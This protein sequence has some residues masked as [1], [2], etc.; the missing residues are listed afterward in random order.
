MTTKS[1]NADTGS[2]FDASN[3]SPPS[4][5]ATGDEVI[6]GSGQPTIDNGSAITGELIVLGGSQNATAATLTAINTTFGPTAAFD[7]TLTATGGNPSSDTLDSVL[8][9]EGDT[10]FSGRIQV[11]AVGGSLTINSQKQGT[12][13]ANLTL[14]NTSEIQV[15]RESKLNLTGERITNNAAIKVNGGAE[16]AADLVVTGSGSIDVENGGVLLVEGTIDSK[17][18]VYLRDG[19]GDLHISNS[20]K[21]L[22]SIGLEDPGARIDLADLQ[23]QSAAYDSTAQQ[24]TLYSG[25]N[26]TGQ[27]L[28]TFDIVGN[29]LSTNDFRLSSDGGGGTLV[30]YAPWV[31][32]Y[33]PMPVPVVAKA[34]TFVSLSD[35]MLQSFGTASPGFYGITLQ[36]ADPA[37]A[38]G[39]NVGYWVPGAGAVA[40]VWY[41]NGSPITTESYQVQAS[42][43]VELLVGNS[44]KPVTIQAQLT[45]GSA[46]GAQVFTTYD[47]FMTDPA[48]TAR[49]TGTPTAAEVVAS[50]QSNFANYPIVPN[51]N[52]CVIIA[53]NVPAAAGAPI[54][55]GWDSQPISDF[56][57]NSDGGFWR[58]VYNSTQLPAPPANWSTEVEPGDTVSVLWKNNGGGHVF[59][60]LKGVAGN[61]AKIKVYDNV[62]DPNAKDDE[63]EDGDL[64][65]PHI[66]ISD[67]SYWLNTEPDKVLI[68]RLDPK[69]QYLIRGSIESELIQGSVYNNLINPG[70]G[71][72][73]ITAGLGNN[74]IQDTAQSLNGIT[75]TDF[76]LGDLFNFTNLGLSGT[77][78]SYAAGKLH[79]FSSGSEVAAVTMS[80]PKPGE[81]VAIATDGGV[82]TLIGLSVAQSLS[83]TLFEASLVPNFDA[84][85]T[86][87]IMSYLENAGIYDSALATAAVQKSSAPS[88][89]PFADIAEFSGA[90]I[91]PITTATGLKAIIATALNSNVALTGSRDV[92]L[93]SGKGDDL[94]NLRDIGNDLIVAG[95]GNDTIVTGQGRDTV[96]AGDGN[97]VVWAGQ[98]GIE[99]STNVWGGAGDDIIGDISS[100]QTLYPEGSNRFDGGD[101]NDSLY[102][103][104]SGDD[105]LTG[106]TGNDTLTGA[107]SGTYD[108]D[109]GD[110]NDTLI[111][112]GSGT[113]NLDGGDGNDLIYAAGTGDETA[114]GG[115]GDDQIVATASANYVLEG[116]AGNDRLYATGNGDNSL[117]GG[118]GNDVLFAGGVGN[119]SLSGDDGNDT[120]TGAGNGAYILDG[121][122]GDDLLY[123]RGQEIGVHA[124]GI[125]FETVLGG[126]GNDIILGSGN[127]PYL[128]DGGA[129]GDSVY[130]TGNGNDI[131]Q[132][133]DDADF[134]YVSGAGADSLS[135]GAGDDTVI[136][137]GAGTYTL[138][139]GD[140]NDLIYA[141][142]P[143]AETVLG[144]A[145]NDI[146][147][148]QGNGDYQLD[149]G[150][151]SDSIYALGN[152]NDLLQGDDGN[153]FLYANGSGQDSLT[154]N[155]GDDT[156]V[157]AG[158]GT[159]DLGGGDGN[160]LIYAQGAAGETAFGGAGNDTLQGS[161]AGDDVLDGGAG[162]NRLYGLGTGNETL[163]GGVASGNDTLSVIG[164]GTFLVDA[165][166]ATGNNSIYDGGANN[167]TII[168]GA[169]NDTINAVGDGAY[170]ISGGDGNDLVYLQGSGADSLDAGDGNDIV[171]ASG[172]GHYL[173]NGGAGDDSIYAI[174]SGNDTIDGGDGNDYISTGTGTE[175]DHR[176]RRQR[177]DILQL[178]L[179]RP[180]HPRRWRGQR[181]DHVPGQAEE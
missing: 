69:Q 12:T 9:I 106:G 1:W 122:G 123:A 149:G 118:I 100:G 131:L 40:P 23:V 112:T 115:N 53:N 89:D 175:F 160:D 65:K 145:G 81:N 45:S 90:H 68:Y 96:Q 143:R 155:D 15:T 111:G 165:S 170:S 133:G 114:S 162:D 172:A 64:F 16:V 84:A 30:T 159:Y 29:N 55:M 178:N 150:T 83:R 158:G 116:G 180:R 95:G 104:G 130:V 108:L 107:G 74:E 144:G 135:G 91:A 21:F 17:Q 139:G 176:R 3:W 70:G 66:G 42:D 88:V 105:S 101:G 41:V 148:G 78:A 39:D 51:R 142:G 125:G 156:V 157:G 18:I 26:H 140:G 11:E 132:G 31:Q 32:L 10:V 98:N 82:G 33:Q 94:L 173:I 167:D 37:D 97:N 36:P 7:M 119:D 141:Q 8:V 117:T 113:Y 20:Q 56:E 124:I 67:Q 99:G 120:L 79:V 47:I 2:W 153:D 151:G 138:D 25:P 75:V 46:G 177:Y 59:T 137:A 80:A 166:G 5:P 161:G 77:T 171:L 35:I 72:D 121:G 60:V 163:I 168:G 44:I 103:G 129:G 136:G 43:D 146:I 164:S 92:L 154:G 63:E 128:L 28:D 86:T 127:G 71:A 169:G 174:G 52:Y 76:H 109:G 4:V 126:D 54:A 102:A 87:Q 48:V 58:I 152:G 181:H 110:G 24:L 93:A 13:D 49:V 6:I 85:A 179:G 134:V 38:T 62:F 27:V 19:T 50:A 34:G 14:S 147:L 57:L 22:G 73:T 61:P